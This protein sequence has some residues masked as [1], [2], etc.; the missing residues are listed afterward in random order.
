MAEKLTE[1]TLK[2][3]ANIFADVF[4]QKGI[5]SSN[6]ST[7]EK[8]SQSGG[9]QLDDYNT[10]V[11]QEEL[12]KKNNKLLDDYLDLQKTAISKTKDSNKLKN[13][14]NKIEKELQRDSI[15]LGNSYVDAVN[16]F[17]NNKLTVGELKKF[18]NDEDVN[19]LTKDFSSQMSDAG[20]TMSGTLVDT[21]EQ[22]HTKTSRLVDKSFEMLYTKGMFGASFAQ[23]LGQ[24]RSGLKYGADMTSLTLQK[25]V[26]AL[27]MG[28]GTS[29][30]IELEAKNKRL[31][32]ALGGA[33]KFEQAIATGSNSMFKFYGSL[34]ESTKGTIH[35][36]HSLSL[37]GI[38][39]T[40][41]MMTDQNGELSAL[42]KTMFNIRGMTGQ[43]FAEQN[44]AMEQYIQSDVTKT[45]LAALSTSKERFNLIQRD[46]AN[47]EMLASLGLTAEQANRVSETFNAIAG[48]DPKERLKESYK[49][50]A[51]AA[52]MG[53]ENAESIGQVMRAGGLDKV[54][55]EVAANYTKAMG[56]L[57]KK[58]ADAY[59][60]AISSSGLMNSA[61]LGVSSAL[62]DQVKGSKDLLLADE[63]RA[64][65]AK[66]KAE[67]DYIGLMG[68][69]MVDSI[70]SGLK[71]FDITKAGLA[72]NA[73]LT[74]I[75]GTVG[76]IATMMRGGIGGAR[77]HK[78]NNGGG[79]DDLKKNKPN[80]PGKFQNAKTNLGRAA[81]GAK[82][83]ATNLGR[84]TLDKGK[85]I[86]RM[87]TKG[88]AG[89][90]L[91]MASKGINVAKGAG[92]KLLGG[93][94]KM[95]GGAGKLL[96]KLAW[97]IAAAQAVGDGIVG[98]KN[99]DKA[100]DTKKITTGMKAASA[101]GGVV[102]GLTFGL[103]DS[104]SVAKMAYGEVKDVDKNVVKPKDK[105]L[106]A[107]DLKEKK[108]PKQE[109]ASPIM[110]QLAR[111]QEENTA[112]LKMLNDTISDN[113]DKVHT[114]NIK[115]LKSSDGIKTT[116][117]ESKTDGMSPM[118][119]T[120]DGFA[121]T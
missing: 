104:A 41:S 78:R 23:F 94:G 89:K 8:P 22:I 42:N 15:L 9:S 112:I 84:A 10:R 100:F 118:D 101:L 108:V 31:V 18:A 59:G 26:D 6:V 12:L 27:K 34:E 90:G 45:K 91:G 82:E 30:L 87:S 44:A 68:S 16:S 83:K 63:K 107:P 49:A 39:P 72:G 24:F 115:K 86:A 29:E 2:L 20:D 77:K 7:I 14:Q 3:Y 28:I 66:M 114:A 67:G 111:L 102:S 54:G 113:F 46:Q 57:S 48:L 4:K 38:K 51:V 5:M 32:N 60:G 69:K 47:K 88:I 40:L 55:P 99:A 106:N 76:Y 21:A 116:L 79:F 1:A 36:L 50:Q 93:A 35:A 56:Q 117:L 121:F 70:S 58:Q 81:S 13:E 25:N 120:D 65:E 119:F 80:K 109:E 11:K 95:M 73:L 43:T 110:T 61:L 74:S 62:N 17:K 103:V 75:L 37:G 64:K 53:V 52:A 19:K 105:K 98:W 71:L 33:E 97:P 96:G 85:N 92:G